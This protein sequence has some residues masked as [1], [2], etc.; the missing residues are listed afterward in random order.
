MKYLCSDIRDNWY[1]YPFTLATMLQSNAGEAYKCTTQVCK[2]NEKRKNIDWGYLTN[3]T[4][5]CEACIDLCDKER[6]CQAV[7]CGKND[8]T[9]WKNDEC[10]TPT[11]VDKHS[12]KTCIKLGLV[13][14]KWKQ[15]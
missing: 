5:N 15:N 2:W 3:Q 7:E 8:C 4:V 13:T 14:R 1:P 9:W 11:N 12:R 6:F 10:N